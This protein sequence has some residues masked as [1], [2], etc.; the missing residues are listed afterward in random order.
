MCY[1]PTRFARRGM[2]HEPFLR[3]NITKPPCTVLETGLSRSCFQQSRIHT[4][5]LDRQYY[6]KYCSRI[7][8][9]V[10]LLSFAKA[11][12]PSDL[13]WGWLASW[14]V[15]VELHCEKGWHCCRCTA[16]NKWCMMLWFVVPKQV[17][18]SQTNTKATT[19]LSLPCTTYRPQR[20]DGIGGNLF[21]VQLYMHGPAS[22]SS[23][24]QIW[25]YRNLDKGQ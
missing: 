11:W 16:I 1:L 22:P 21:P 18:H 5:L 7:E 10:W 17:G 12:V 14:A 9:L 19:P 13:R 8:Q 25:Q 6:W 20:S 2:N 24:S 3:S 15:H 4:W 23:Q